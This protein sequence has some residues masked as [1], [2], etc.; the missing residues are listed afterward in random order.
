M[1]NSVQHPDEE[2]LSYIKQG[3]KID[4]KGSI[5]S[6]ECLCCS[7][8]DSSFLSLCLFPSPILCKNK[9]PFLL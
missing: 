6:S 4:V 1:Q 8:G 2:L 3:V 5:L 9:S 7:L